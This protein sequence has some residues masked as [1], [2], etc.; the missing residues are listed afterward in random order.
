MR[1]R[2]ARV[3]SMQKTTKNSNSGKAR[4]RLEASVTQLPCRDVKL[5]CGSVAAWQPDRHQEHS[6]IFSFR[7]T[8]R[9]MIAIEKASRRQERPHKLHGAGQ[10]HM[11]GTRQWQPLTDDLRSTLIPFL[12]LDSIEPRPNELPCRGSRTPGKSGQQYQ[13]APSPYE[14]GA[15]RVIFHRHGPLVFR[16]LASTKVEES[17]T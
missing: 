4:H 14:V 10:E 6:L 13:K 11:Q 8:A 9:G 7:Q 17:V 3:Y 15:K 2:C 5:S 12:T 16:Y 1:H